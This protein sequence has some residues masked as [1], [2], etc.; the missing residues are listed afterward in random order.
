MTHNWQYNH[1]RSMIFEDRESQSCPMGYIEIESTLH[2]LRCKSQ[3]GAISPKLIS[4]I[5]ESGC[6]V[7]PQPHN[8]P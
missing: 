5:L 3:P 4:M 6:G 2:H 1:S 8:L 7:L